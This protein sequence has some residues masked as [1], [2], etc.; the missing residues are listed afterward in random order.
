M[1]D[2]QPSELP[3]IENQGQAKAA[4]MIR[5]KIWI[6]VIVLSGVAFFLFYLFSVLDAFEWI[7]E[8]NEVHADWEIDELILSIALVTSLGFVFLVRRYR[9]ML[10]LVRERGKMLNELMIAHETIT[11][12]KRRL[13]NAAYSDFLTGLPNRA[14]LLK[15]LEHARSC[16]MMTLIFFDIDLFKQVNDLHG[17]A[18]GDELI[19]EVAR[20][21]TKVLQIERGLAP[22]DSMRAAIRLAGDEFVIVVRDLKSQEQVRELAQ[23]LQDSLSSPYSLLGA[24]VSTTASIGVAMNSHP[25]EGSEHLL[26]D[27]DAAMYQAKL[28]GRGRIKYFEPSM[29]ERLTRRAQLAVDLKEAIRCSQL[30]LHYHPI[31]SLDTGRLEGTESLVR[32]H[33]PVL[34][35]ISPAEFI[36][37]A[38]ESDLIFD[39]GT[40]VLEQSLQQMSLW[41]SNHPHI[42][43]DVISVNVSRK[44]FSDPHMIEKFS[45][46]LETSDVPRSRIQLEITEDVGEIDLDLVVKRMH[47]LK[48]L[49]VKIAIDDFGTGTSTFAAIKSFPIDTVKLDI[50]LVSQIVNSIDRAAIVHSLAILVRNLN[51]KMVAEGVE[52]AQQIPVLQE[53]GCHSAQGFYFSKPLG[54]ED[55]EKQ[56]EFFGTH[57]FTVE[58]YESFPGRWKEKLVAFKELNA[59]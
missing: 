18:I 30:H 40:W 15:H 42:A 59:T 14:W 28:E 36:P 52:T 56:M 35:G 24:S 32:W 58:G 10:A 2:S 1:I 5:R 48:D 45:A 13:R 54:A 6:D 44:Q 37:I 33:H 55:F 51:V 17:H 8:L 20:R 57:G 47:Q 11:N 53:L 49:G 7:V 41:I 16:E 38:E 46:I 12:D 43:P 19:R 27:A 21:S 31:L 50:S 23:Q 34:G 25:A 29:R 4:K 39:L 9:E 26:G 22:I 3:K